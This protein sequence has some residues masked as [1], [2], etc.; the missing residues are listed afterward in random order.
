MQPPSFVIAV[1][2]ALT[3]AATAAS[4]QTFQASGSDVVPAASAGKIVTGAHLDADGTDVANVRVFGYG[5]QADPLDPF[6][7]Q[8]PGFNA[9]AGSGLPAGGTLAFTVL[10]SLSYWDG[11][12]VATFGAVPNAESLQY[13]FGI[14]NALITGVSGPQPGFSIGTV[15]AD[16]SIHKHLNAFLNGSDGNSDPADGHPPTNGIYSAGLR[17]TD[18]GVADSDPLYVVYDNGLPLA[19]LDRAKFRLRNYSAPGTRLAG[20]VT[21]LIG[22]SPLPGEANLATGGQVGVTGG[23]GG[24]ASEID[25][26]TANAGRGS[27]AIAH[28]GSEGR[29]LAMLWLMGTDADVRSLIASLDGQAGYDVAASDAAVSDPLYADIRQLSAAYPGFRAL[30]AFDPTTDNG[31]MT[32]DFAA[33]PGVQVD[34]VAV[35][36]EP[37]A[38][39]LAAAAGA[40]GAGLFGRGRRRRAAARLLAVN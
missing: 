21:N 10:S 5:F 35:V 18:T 6:F 39:G 32:W 14:K 9:P 16:G 22:L 24:Y 3:L 40:L 25:D 33:S 7:T 29:T 23:N 31:A 34:K 13:T 20:T 12:G 38:G 19:A 36:P 17:L 2:L 28:V 15:A 8:D 1:P 4:G 30:V 11:S 27:V 37:T 26:L